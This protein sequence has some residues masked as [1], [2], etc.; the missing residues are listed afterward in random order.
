MYL[1]SFITLHG[2]TTHRL[3][4]VSDSH[5][6]LAVLLHL[7]DELHGQHPA[8][9]SLTELLRRSIQ[10]APKAVP[11]THKLKIRSVASPDS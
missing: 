10:S 5:D 4:S 9:K 8:V 7:V 1:N 6:Q 11:L 2:T 3:D